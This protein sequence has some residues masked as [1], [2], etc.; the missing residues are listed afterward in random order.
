MG[1]GWTADGPLTE[2]A[3][4]PNINQNSKNTS[5][6]CVE[7]RVYEVKRPADTRYILF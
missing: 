6:E 2:I 5:S 4:K 3:P 1:Q 7:S